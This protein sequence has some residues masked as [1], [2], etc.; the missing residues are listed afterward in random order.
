MLSL[1]INK[2]SCSH[3]LRWKNLEHV[4]YEQQWPEGCKGGENGFRRIQLKSDWVQKKFEE[5]NDFKNEEYD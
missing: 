5:F 3:S 2:K 4:L 1:E